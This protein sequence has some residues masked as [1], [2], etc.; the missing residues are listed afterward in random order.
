MSSRSFKV[1]DVD[2]PEKLTPSVCYNEEHVFVFC[3]RFFTL[4]E[5]VAVNL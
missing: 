2:T 3:N 5:L 4:D 1:I